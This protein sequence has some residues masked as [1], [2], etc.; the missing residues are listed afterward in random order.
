MFLIPFAAKSS[1]IFRSKRRQSTEFDACCRY[2]LSNLFS[3]QWKMYSWTLERTDPHAS[4][5]GEIEFSPTRPRFPASWSATVMAVSRC[6]INHVVD[7]LTLVMLLMLRSNIQYNTIGA[8]T[9]GANVTSK[10]WCLIALWI[11]L[12]AVFRSLKKTPLLLLKHTAFPTLVA[13]GLLFLYSRPLIFAQKAQRAKRVEK[14]KEKH[15]GKRIKRGGRPKEGRSY[16][17]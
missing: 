10:V 11:S 7:V 9:A 16:R 14:K 12:D 6:G 17:C 8:T 13:R 1:Y 4:A 3:S 5:R 15:N 2:Y